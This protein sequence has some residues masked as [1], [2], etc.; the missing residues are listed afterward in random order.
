MKQI[1]RM[2]I[3]LLAG[4]VFVFSCAKE[5]ADN[6][7]ELASGSE[8]EEVSAPAGKTVTVSAILSDVVTKVSF[9][10]TF[11]AGND[12][13][14]ESLALCWESTDK[15]LVADHANPDNSALFDLTGGEGTKK[16]VFTGTAP[17]GATS[18]DVS[19][20]HGTLTYASQTQADDGDASHLQLI[21]SKKNISD[22][23]TITF[24]E[25]NSVLA[26]T[27]LMPEGVAGGIRYVDITAME[28]DGQTPANIFGTGNSLTIRLGDN[29]G[30]DDYLHLFAVL[31]AGDTEIPAGTT[32]LMHFGAPET[33]HEVY[34]RFVTLGSGLTFTAGKLNTINVNASQSDK[35]AGLPTCDGTTA[36]K[37]YLIGDKYQMDS[38]NVLAPVAATTCFKMIDDVNMK[39]MAAIDFN[40]NVSEY[41]KKVDFNGNNK[42]ISKLNKDMFYVFKGSIY[43]LTLDSCVVSSRGILAEYIQGT[44]NTI[45]NVNVTNGT[46]ICTSEKT[47]GLVGIV[48]N[49]SSNV[50]AVTISGCHIMNTNVTVSNNKGNAG[51]LIGF[52]DAKVEVDNC[53]VSKTGTGTYT[54]KGASSNTG[55]LIGNMG[56]ENNTTAI[57]S[58][59]SNCTVSGIN[60]TGVGVVGG[61]VGFANTLVT[62][63]GSK[64]S[65]GTVSASQ[66][67]CGGF[68]GSTANQ[69]SIISDCRVESAI[70]KSSLTNDTRL[71]GFVGQLQTNVKVKGCSVGTSE[72]KVTV[73]THQPDT[74]KVLN[75]GGFVGVNYGTITKNGDVRCK[76]YVEVTSKNKIGQPLN[77]GGFVGFHRGTIEYC[78][79]IVDMSDLQGQYI[80]GFAGYSVNNET[81][82]RHNTVQGSVKGNNYTGGFVGYVDNHTITFSDNEVLDGTVVNGQSSVGGFA[83]CTAAGTFS[84]N[85]VAGTI[86]VRGN[87][88]GGFVGTTNGGSFTDCS[89][90]AAVTGNGTVIGGFVGYGVVANMTRCSASG[91]VV[92]NTANGNQ[93]GGFAGSIETCTLDGCNSSGSVT[94][95]GITSEYV[96][97]FIGNVRPATDALASIQNCFSTGAVNGSGRWT[98]G[99]IGYIYRAASDCGN[100]EIRKCYSTSPVAVSGKSYVAGFI[101]RTYMVT[102]SHLTIEKSY[103]TGNV[104][105]NQSY[106]SAF[107]GEI[108]EATTCSISDCYSTGNIVG[109]NQV[110]GGLIAAV[111]AN[112]ATS[113]TISRCY[114]TSS[115]SD[116]SFRLGGLIGN[117]AGTNCTMED[118]AAWNGAVTATSYSYNKNW[119]SGTIVGTAHPNCHLAN[120]FRKPGMTVTMWWAPAADYDHP[121]VE[122]TTHPLVIRNNEAP[123]TYTEATA[124]TLGAPYQF[125]YH[126][127]H[128]TQTRLSTL[129]SMAKGASSGQGGLGWSSEVWDFTGDLPTLK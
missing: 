73:S 56:S 118:C 61:V 87:N 57:N 88:G 26:I 16:A 21:A 97:G 80:G 124:T 65:G 27:A 30:D 125:P 114:S 119:S 40:R 23:S 96:G 110:R 107:I 122:G 8:S 6:R 39:G 120:N 129:A 84:N 112:D 24:D 13:K 4:L 91:A 86:T 19:V 64:Y 20:V 37:A 123:Y 45:T 54:V 29:T 113:V 15:L 51:G 53:T 74:G 90:S 72:T 31:P 75:A 50:T 12:K 69:A 47:G 89:S 70:V 79:A 34:T 35:H 11:D 60:V 59:I 105:S 104:S 98:G 55:G 7:K 115:L 100:V 111:N 17:A 127:W 42:T 108:G 101:G 128:T 58:S 9:D 121:D 62:I 49:G 28:A 52:V 76:A 117:I 78:D 25:L 71:G 85:T 41:S 5:Q 116:G 14:L 82:A 77:L 32:L 66:R 94:T 109:S 68:M 48:N 44:G 103:A 38:M 83:G 46:V 2:S 126:G 33:A 67:Y 22:L 92:K 93:V 43:D 63:S 81:T 36:D 1:N 99:F 102:G 106:A 95:T 3:L 10:P 18:Y